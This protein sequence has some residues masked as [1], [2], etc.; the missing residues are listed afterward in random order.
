MRIFVLFMLLIVIAAFAAFVSLNHG[1]IIDSI[2]LG[3]TIFHDI[4]LNMV[5]VWAFAIG[6]LWALLIFSIQ[7]IRLRLRISRLRSSVRELQHELDQLR[8]MPLS[9]NGIRDKEGK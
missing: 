3:F 7:E 1:I 8:I 2:S 6:V 9:D 5:V 4:T